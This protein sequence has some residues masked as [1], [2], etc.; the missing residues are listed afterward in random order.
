MARMIGK[1]VYTLVTLAIRLNV[2]TA[3]IRPQTLN[4]SST[5][6]SESAVFKPQYCKCILYGVRE[7]SCTL[8]MSSPVRNRTGCNA[9][10]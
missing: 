2:Q 8:S 9:M 1:I 6:G 10:S 7:N 4:V 3:E 5:Q